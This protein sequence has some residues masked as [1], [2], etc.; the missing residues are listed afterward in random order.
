MSPSAIEL[1][2]VEGFFPSAM[3]ADDR[4]KASSDL[5]TTFAL[6]ETGTRLSRTLLDQ[7]QYLRKEFLGLAPPSG[8]ITDSRR[9]VRHL[10][11]TADFVFNVWGKTDSAFMSGASELDKL[12]LEVLRSTNHTIATAMLSRFYAEWSEQPSPARKAEFMSVLQGVTAF[13]TLWRTSRATT[14]G[15][16]DAHRKLMALGHPV[17]GLPPLAWRPQQGSS[18][19]LPTAA[20]VRSALRNVLKDRGSIQSAADW[21]AR[22]TVQPLYQTS[23][24]LAKFVLLAS[25]EDRVDD[26]TAPGLIKRGVPGAFSCLTLKAWR[27]HYSV[28]HI[29]P[30][31]LAAGDISYEPAIYDQGMIDRLGNLT[32]MPEDLNNLVSNRTW[33]Y[34]QDLYQ[35]LSM[36]DPLARVAQMQQRLAGLAPTTRAVLEAADYLPFCEFLPNQSSA[37][38]SASFLASRGQRLAELAVERLWAMLA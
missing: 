8:N 13:W 27:A 34:K 1:G 20:A 5:L 10:A 18:S 16:D 9:L 36:T 24:Q 6:A 14:K 26:L 31:V 38:L 28:E 3:R 21:V 32:L 2:R 33:Q 19:S 22:A 30:Q 4:S 12:C 15:I 11:N 35:V 17:T 7:R 23:R 29:A 25:H 37:A